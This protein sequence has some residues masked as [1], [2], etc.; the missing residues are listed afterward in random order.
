MK[1][2]TKCWFASP[3]KVPQLQLESPCLGMLQHPDDEPR[4]NPPMSKEDVMETIRNAPTRMRHHREILSNCE[5]PDI[6][7]LPAGQSLSYFPTISTGACELQNPGTGKHKVITPVTIAGTTFLVN[8]TCNRPTG[9]IS[10]LSLIK[11]KKVAFLPDAQRD[12]F[13]NDWKKKRNYHPLAVNLV[14]CINS[15]EKSTLQSYFQKLGQLEEF[16]EVHFP[17]RVCDISLSKILRLPEITDLLIAF[18]HYK[19]EEGVGL[20]TLQTY[21]VSVNFF[22]KVLN[23]GPLPD[24]HRIK[25]A[26]KAISR[27]KCKKPVSTRAI[28]Y[29]ILRY[30]FKFLRRSG[31]RHFAFFILSF[32]AGSRASEAIDISTESFTFYR[33]NNDKRAVKLTFNRPKTRKK[34]VDDSHSVFFTLTPMEYKIC[35]YRIAKHLCDRLPKGTFIGPF[36][37]GKKSTRLNRMYRWFSQIKIEFP[38]WYLQETGRRIDTS[39]WRFH[40]IRTTLIGVL[41]NANLS[42]SHIQ[43]R[44]GHKIDSKTTRD[45]YYMNAILTEGFDKAFDNMIEHNPEIQ[46]I[47]GKTPKSAQENSESAV[48]RPQNHSDNFFQP[49]CIPLAPIPHRETPFVPSDSDQSEQSQE[50]NV[51]IQ[52]ARRRER[53]RA[54]KRKRHT[55]KNPHCYKALQTYKRL[56]SEHYQD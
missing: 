42:W 22:R 35:P 47:M 49:A 41:R 40:S 37:P 54:P 44:V 33:T 50:I 14:D 32:W 23:I 52:N 25:T 27:R 46:A 48:E 43:L 12:R 38:K 31:Y 53:E 2:L 29:F 1:Y 15:I 19:G 17:E 56:R 18:L 3:T 6:T 16:W 10:N 30:L 8:P 20:S 11:L 45:T 39:L 36:G 34:Y 55:H 51:F 4:E 9:A 13:F 24:F 26:V 7:S 28:P 5:V 21:P